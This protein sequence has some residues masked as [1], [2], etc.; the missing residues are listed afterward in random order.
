ML[1]ISSVTKSF[2]N[3]EHTQHL[4]KYHKNILTTFIHISR[5]FLN[6]VKKF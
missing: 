5:Y 1:C 3:K 2:N 4:I 6:V